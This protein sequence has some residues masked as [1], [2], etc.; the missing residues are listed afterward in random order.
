[1]SAM[2]DALSAASLV[3]AAL[4]LVYSAWSGSIE[5]ALNEKLGTTKD[6]VAAQKKEWAEVRKY[7]ALPIA[8]ACWALLIIFLCRDISILCGAWRCVGSPNCRYDDIAVIFLLTQVL[9]LGMALHTTRKAGEIKKR[10]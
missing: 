2:S 1:M 5:R 6:Q 4:A 7:R 8:Y 10:L 9:I 3:L